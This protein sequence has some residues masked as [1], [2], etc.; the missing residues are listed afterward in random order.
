[1]ESNLE[2]V[3]AGDETNSRW[4]GYFSGDPWNKRVRDQGWRWDLIAT[5]FGQPFCNPHQPLKDTPNKHA[6]WVKTGCLPCKCSCRVSPQS[7]STS[8][9]IATSKS[10][11]TLI[12]LGTS[13]PQKTVFDL[14]QQPSMVFQLDESTGSNI[15]LFLSTPGKSTA[16]EMHPLSWLWWPIPVVSIQCYL[17]STA[18]RI[19]NHLYC[20]CRFYQLPENDLTSTWLLNDKWFFPFPT[21]SLGGLLMA[22]REKKS[23]KYSVLTH[24]GVAL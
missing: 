6:L 4:K 13:E 2:G 7:H 14:H 12:D 20:C 16:S 15:I 22:Q 5:N 11:C 3:G 21:F 8:K 19:S 23:R 18:V 9:E 1:M 24:T 10:L 17:T